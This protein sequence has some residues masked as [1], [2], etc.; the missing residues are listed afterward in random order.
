MRKCWV[1]NFH[2]ILFLVWNWLHFFLSI[3]LNSIEHKKSTDEKNY[4]HWDWTVVLKAKKNHFHKIKC[5]LVLSEIDHELPL[6]LNKRVGWLECLL[7]KGQTA[8]IFNHRCLWKLTSQ[9]SKICKK[10]M[11]SHCCC[12]CLPK[13][14]WRKKIPKFLE[15]F[16]VIVQ[17]VVHTS[18]IFK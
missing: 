3:F 13:I 8:S 14:N 10:W 7:P 4:S 9:C 6:T 12:L 17:H 15:S 1:R 11:K 2:S 18:K 16:E 5:W